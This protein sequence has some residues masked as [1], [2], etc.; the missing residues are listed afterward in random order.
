[1]K[2]IVDSFRSV[3]IHGGR[4][5]IQLVRGGGRWHTRGR[6]VNKFSEPV[7]NELLGGR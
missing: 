4:V 3:V 5:K 2:R 1:M 6:E 7:W